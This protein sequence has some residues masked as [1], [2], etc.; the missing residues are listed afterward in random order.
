MT[1]QPLWKRLFAT[2]E[3]QFPEYSRRQ[4]GALVVY[5]DDAYFCGPPEVT[6]VAFNF[7]L[8]EGPK[9]G[10][11]IKA[12]KGSML[13]G[14]YASVDEAITDFNAFKEFINPAVIHMHPDNLR[15]AVELELVNDLP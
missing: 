12:N 9:Y 10:Y 8:E 11:H 14:K 3:Q 13:L 2:L 15:E 7:L 6:Q 4:L 5:V 1:T